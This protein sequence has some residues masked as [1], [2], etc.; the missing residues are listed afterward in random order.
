MGCIFKRFDESFRNFSHPTTEVTVDIIALNNLNEVCWAP[1]VVNY[2]AKFSAFCSSCSS[3]LLSSNPKFSLPFEIR[4]NSLFDGK[5]FLFFWPKSSFQL[6]RK[7]PFFNKPF[8]E[9]RAKWA[10]WAKRVNYYIAKILFN[11]FVIKTINSKLPK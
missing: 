1:H 9:L 11:L 8:G 2:S 7:S 3:G 4:W 5:C 10:K 6:S